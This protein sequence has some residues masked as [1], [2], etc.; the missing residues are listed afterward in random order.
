MAESEKKNRF[1]EIIK[2][3][4]GHIYQAIGTAIITLIPQ[5]TE[6]A[7]NHIDGRLVKMEKRLTRKIINLLTIGLG[8]MFLIFALLF[9][10]MEF[11]GW[12]T[13]ASLFSIGIVIFVLGLILKIFSS[14]R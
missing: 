4:L 5:G 10:M 11:L 1:M 12:S 2:D 13:Y 9:Y 14:D 8:A 7:M 6:I 3:G